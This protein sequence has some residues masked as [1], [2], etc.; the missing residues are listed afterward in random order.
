[1]HEQS[2]ERGIQ[3]LHGP[4]LELFGVSALDQ[5]VA[6]AAQRRARAELPG[7]RGREQRQELE[8]ELLAAEGEELDEDDLGP[9][10]PGG[11]QE[12]GG[13]PGLGLLQLGGVGRAERAEILAHLQGG[14]REEPRVGPGRGTGT[15][16]PRR[17]NRNLVAGER[18]GHGQAAHEVPQA[19]HVL[20]YC[21][22]LM[23]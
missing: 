11:L 16:R 19:E 23:A 12:E 9:E 14:E 1:V 4:G 17:R 2:G 6:Q 10:G 20:A 21:R 8:G 13:A 7:A 22:I 18:P 5:D 3:P 15:R